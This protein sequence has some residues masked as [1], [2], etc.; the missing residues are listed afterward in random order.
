MSKQSSYDHCKHHKQILS[1]TLRNKLPLFWLGSV[2]VSFQLYKFVFVFRSD[3]KKKKKKKKSKLQVQPFT[4]VSDKGRVGVCAHSRALSRCLLCCRWAVNTGWPLDCELSENFTSTC[5]QRPKSWKTTLNF[6]LN[7]SCNPARRLFQ[8]VGK[9]WGRSILIKRHLVSNYIQFKNKNNK[10]KKT[11]AL[12]L[13][14]TCRKCCRGN[15][16]SILKMSQD[17]Y[18]GITLS[19]SVRFKLGDNRPHTSGKYPSAK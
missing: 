19:F 11:R 12:C 14:H 6:F 3:L 16:S 7:G 4:G 18:L 1:S 5:P 10:R 2:S 13:S 9:Y 15:H 8:S 17:K